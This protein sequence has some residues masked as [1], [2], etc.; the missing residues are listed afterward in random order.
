MFEGI[1]KMSESHRSHTRLLLV[2]CGGSS[3]SFKRVDMPF[4]S[5]VVLSYII[6][7]SVQ[8]IIESQSSISL[9]GGLKLTRHKKC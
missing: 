9:P 4:L 6:E 2:I 1:I 3:C 7:R 5:R 8:Y